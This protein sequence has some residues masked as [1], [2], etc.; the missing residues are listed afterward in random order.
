ML[1][2]AELCPCCKRKADALCPRCGGKKSPK[3]HRCDRCRR[4]NADNRKREIER[5]RAELKCIRCRKRSVKYQQCKAC[6]YKARLSA[7]E[8]QAEAAKIPHC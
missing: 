5:L 1:S 7:W 8:K 4:R 2:Y 3:Y 6:R